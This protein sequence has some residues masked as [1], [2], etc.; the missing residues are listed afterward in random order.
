MA[1]AS[2]LRTDGTGQVIG[3]SHHDG[4]IAA[5][6]FPKDAQFELRIVSSD[7][8]EISVELLGVEYLALNNL[9]EGNIIDR[10]YLWNF[11][12]APP[13]IVNRM[14]EV[15]SMRSKDVL[16]E[17]FGDGVFIF[18]LEC[19]YGAELFALVRSANARFLG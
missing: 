4:H 18:H 12:K 10:M 6:L 14:L 15:L 9:R 5:I 19:S 17:S 7:G 16:A 8:E 2:E 13:M 1:K 11:A 3:I